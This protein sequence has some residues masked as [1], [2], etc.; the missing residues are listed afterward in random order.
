VE[1]RPV[2]P[3][4]RPFTAPARALVRGV[5]ESYARCLRRERVDV[6]PARALAQVEDYA[7]ALTGCGVIVDWLPTDE[8]CPDAC[9]VEDTAVV[10]DAS[11]ALLTRPGAPSRRAEVPPVA[12]AL[13]ALVTR[14]VDM[15]DD[16]AATLDGGDVLRVG[17]TFFVGLSERTNQAGVDALARAARPLGLAAQAVPLVG[18][19]G[20]HLKS[21]VTLVAPDLAVVTPEVDQAAL[22]ALGVRCLRVDELAGA[23]VLALGRVVLVSAA[24]PGTAARLAREPGLDVRMIDVSELHKG[25]GAL[26]CL[27]LR[28]PPPGAWCA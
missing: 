6:D 28:V 8:A 15:D 4:S 26:T 27:S 13:R 20:L 17:D 24:A 1:E 5:P 7:R 16:P 22:R 12:A 10:L 19:D 18:G 2:P 11:L 21:V 25:D 9:F 14:Q 23:N 3:T